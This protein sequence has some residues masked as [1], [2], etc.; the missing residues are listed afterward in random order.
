MGIEGFYHRGN[1]QKVDEVYC[2]LKKEKHERRESKQRM[3]LAYVQHNISN[4][5][6]VQYITP[7]SSLL[8]HFDTEKFSRAARFRRVPLELDLF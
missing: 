8:L 5:Q 1:F 2:L 6:K 4:V 3:G 7:F